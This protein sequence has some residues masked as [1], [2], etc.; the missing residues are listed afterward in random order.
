M[1]ATGTGWPAFMAASPLI[2]IHAVLAASAIVVGA[3]QLA[4]PKGTP[5][6]RLMGRFWVGA[7]AF[8]AL[9]SFAIHEIRMFGPF[10]PIHLLSIFVLTVLYRAIR[11]ARQGRIAQHRRSM[12]LLYGLGLIIT[13]AFTL[14]PGRL[15]HA[16]LFGG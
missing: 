11:A 2:Q 12:I 6:H 10:S 9:S 13:G 1:S 4:M 16:V 7:M 5:T 14:L 3:A 15:M 8:V